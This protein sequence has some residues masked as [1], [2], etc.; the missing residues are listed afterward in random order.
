MKYVMVVFF[1]L[2]LGLAV[3]FIAQ[4]AFTALAEKG[5]TPSM[6]M[7]VFGGVPLSA[8]VSYSCYSLVEV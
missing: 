5:Y 7:A 2:I 8:P 3:C 1:V 6:T 4:A